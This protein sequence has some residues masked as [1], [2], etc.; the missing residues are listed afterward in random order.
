MYT[1]MRR[2]MFPLALAA[3][4]VVTAEPAWAQTESLGEIVVTARKRDETFRDVPITVNVFTEQSIKS[5]GIEKPADF[6]ALVPN[7]TLVETQNAG[8]AHICSNRPPSARRSPQTEGE[9]RTNNRRSPQGRPRR[10]RRAA[11]CR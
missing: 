5:A 7:M 9:A 4:I 6:I 2:M 10:R 11:D 1:S 3:V 8:N